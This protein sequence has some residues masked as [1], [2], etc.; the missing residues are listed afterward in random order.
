MYCTALGWFGLVAWVVGLWGLQDSSVPYH[1]LH[2]TT[3]TFFPPSVP[4][5]LCSNIETLSPLSATL[6][7]ENACL[8]N[9]QT[10]KCSPRSKSPPFPSSSQGPLPRYTRARYLFLQVCS[11]FARRVVVGSPTHKIDEPY[12][13]DSMYTYAMIMIHISWR[14]ISG[15]G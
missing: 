8:R 5:G 4:C 3:R 10:Q 9:H 13:F 15:A 11:F 2:Y 6:E 12:A 14:K 7:K 1:G